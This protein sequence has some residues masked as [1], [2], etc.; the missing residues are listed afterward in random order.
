MMVVY[1]QKDNMYTDGG[2]TNVCGRLLGFEIA[3]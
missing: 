3:N 2:P 1:L